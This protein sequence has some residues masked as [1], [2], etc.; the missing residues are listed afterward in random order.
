MNPT[1]M[2]LLRFQAISAYITQEPP[3]GKR[4][5]VLEKLAEKT[6]LL[7]DGRPVSF[8]AETL[9]SWVRRYRDGGLDALEDKARPSRGVQALTEEQVELFCTLKREVPERS[10]DRLLLIAEDLKLVAPGSVSRS[11]LHRALQARGL[12]GR[13]KPAVSDTDLDRFEAEAPNDLWQSDLLVGPWLPD[14]GKP[15]KRRRAVLYAFLD[16][17]SRLLLAGRWSFKGDLPALELV[18]RQALRRHGLCR[19][20]YYDNGATYRSRHMRQVVASLG[21][22]NLVF[23]TAYRP[24]GHGKIE[25]FNR[26]CRSA[27]IAEVKASSIETLDGLNAA[28]TAWVERFYNRRPHGETNEPPRDRWR[29]D[30]ER[31]QHLDEEVLRRAFLWSET[32]KADKTGVFSLFGRRYQVGCDLARKKVEL[33]YDPERLEELEVWFEGRFRERVQPFQVQPN[34]RPR[35]KPGLAPPVPESEGDATPVAD[36]LGHLVA[37]RDDALAE[38]PE[39]ELKRELERR[40]LLDEAFVDV[41]RDR[42]DEVVFDESTVRDWLRHYGPLDTEPVIELLDFAV[43]H[44][45][46]SQHVQQYLDALHAALFEGGEA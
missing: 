26:F 35:P 28:F 14:P 29:R 1:P 39:A 37:E 20:V 23:T 2:A 33:R 12:S 16:D 19:A 41:L 46:P 42:L 6:W 32:R 7:P 34:R 43:E 31:V 18:F 21:I 24:M 38:D 8:S 11:T 36:W 4:R 22:H 40:R 45:G 13:P 27:F 44:M 3:R 17:H 5:A 30:I 10:L 25:A 9:R 15:G